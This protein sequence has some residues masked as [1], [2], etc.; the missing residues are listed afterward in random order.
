MKKLVAVFM[1]VTIGCGILVFGAEGT[2]AASPNA[3]F[4]GQIVPKTKRVSRKV[5]RRSKRVT[6]T[7]W[8][9]GKR[10]TKKVWRKSYRIGRKTAHKTKVVVMGR[11][12]RRP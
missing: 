6:I 1:A 9:H 5:Y 8:R 12:T 3:P 10:V 2:A 11:K 4:A 7:T